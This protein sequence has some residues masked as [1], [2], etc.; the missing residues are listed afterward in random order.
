MLAPALL[1][2]SDEVVAALELVA[3]PFPTA[4]ARVLAGVGA[5]RIP[6]LVISAAGG[7]LV[8]I[9]KTA[10]EVLEEM[11]ALDAA[12]SEVSTAIAV[13]VVAAEVIVIVLE[14]RDAEELCAS[15]A[16]VCCA[17]NPARN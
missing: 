17:L 8:W 5:T 1:T 11:T 6:V 13:L 7:T 15:G 9:V 14:G 10:S 16:P 4:E 3:V 12:D 2:T